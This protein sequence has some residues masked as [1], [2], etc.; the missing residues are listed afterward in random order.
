M[1][2]DLCIMFCVGSALDT[3]KNNNN[4]KN[5]KKVIVNRIPI[6]SHYNSPSFENCVPYPAIERVNLLV[7]ILAIDRFHTMGDRVKALFPY[8]SSIP[9]LPFP[10]PARDHFVFIRLLMYVTC[11][12]CIEH[13][14][15]IAHRCKLKKPE[16]RKVL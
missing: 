6:C 13:C 15:C 10:L 7:W 9:S 14:E 2:L 1:Y 3:T 8:K 12:R 11:P 4:T 5:N 16:H